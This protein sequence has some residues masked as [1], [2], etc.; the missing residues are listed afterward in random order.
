MFYIRRLF[1]IKSTSLFKKSSSFCPKELYCPA[2]LV[3]GSTVSTGCSLA[4]WLFYPSNKSQP[5]L[6]PTI[7]I[8]IPPLVSSLNRNN[9]KLARRCQY[10]FVTSN[11]IQ[12]KNSKDTSNS[13]H[14]L[15]STEQLQQCS[16]EPHRA[17]R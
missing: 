13:T 9:T 11:I 14:L 12:E 5:R 16:G 17:E 7:S 2:A 1:Y 10:D 4:C 15:N 3:R 8:L 6:N